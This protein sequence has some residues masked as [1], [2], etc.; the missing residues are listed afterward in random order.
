MMGKLKETNDHIKADQK[1]LHTYIKSMEK[2]DS[3]IYSKEKLKLNFK[4]RA[5]LASN[6]SHE[7]KQEDDQIAARE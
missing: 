4:G 6:I 5:S 7:L 2:D 3:L 1:N